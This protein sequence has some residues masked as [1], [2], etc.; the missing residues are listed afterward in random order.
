MHTHTPM[1]E[2]LPR[3]WADKTWDQWVARSGTSP[4]SRTWTFYRE[5]LSWVYD[6][7]IKPLEDR[8]AALEGGGTD[9]L[10]A[11]QVKAIINDSQIVAPE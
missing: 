11:A 6:R 5:D 8:V 4:E 7:I 9:G 2:D 10:N 3:D 1:P